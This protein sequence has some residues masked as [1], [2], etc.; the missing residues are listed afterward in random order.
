MLPGYT[1]YV[2]KFQYILLTPFLVREPLWLRGVLE[3]WIDS[4]VGLNLATIQNLKEPY[5]NSC[6]E[7]W[8]TDL[9]KAK[10][11][12]HVKVCSGNHWAE[13]I[14]TIFIDF[15]IFLLYR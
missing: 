7:S 14:R 6:R 4:V 8:P 9:W 13:S 15:Q 1:T 3:I 11:D 5:E 10:L 2:G 12:A